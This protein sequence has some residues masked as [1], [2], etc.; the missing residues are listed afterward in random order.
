MTTT[1]KSLKVKRAVAVS[2]T[3]AARRD[4]DFKKL[5]NDD[6]KFA[7]DLLCLHRSP[8]EVE[9]A[10]EIERRITAGIWL[11]FENPPPPL[12]NVPIWLQ[13]WPFC[14]LWRQRV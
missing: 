2:L 5:S 1:I 10:N 8:Y 9:C 3:S 12:H 7:Y 6:L 14:L 11:D 13:K 4:T